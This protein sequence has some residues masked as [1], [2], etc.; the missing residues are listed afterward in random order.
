[1]ENAIPA[2]IPAS[3]PIIAPIDDVLPR[4]LWSVMIPTYNCTAFLKEALSS[5]LIQALGPE[6]MQIEVVDDASTD[7]DVAAVV[8]ALGGGRVQYFRQPVNVGS[9]RNFETCLNR[10][11][12]QLIHLLHGNDRV[13]TGFYERLT[14]L[15]QL[16]PTAGAASTHYAFIDEQGHRQC[17][18]APAPVAAEA[19]LLPN[20]L[21]RI[22]EYQRLQYV[23]VAVRRQ[24][25]EQ[26]GSFYGTSYGE[27]W[28]MWVRIAAHYPMAYDP[29]VLAEYRG[30][31]NSI[32][33]EKARS[34][35]I[36]PDLIQVI[37][38]IQQHLPVAD[39]SR[40]LSLSKRYYARMGIGT[41]YQALSEGQHW[42][43]ARFQIKQA[44][45]LSKHPSIY[46]H[47]LKFY[48]KRLLR[49]KVKS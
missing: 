37:A 4:P 32:S 9:I 21:L 47:V 12:G 16:Y 46:Y 10:A 44:L 2:R 7:E 38:F 29:T 25:Y 41:A 39:R 36:I 14:Q 24:V 13:T 23:S 3:P 11:R 48:L 45:A 43:L 49:Y 28:E 34:G 17:T 20:W 8:A 42:S 31:T 35:Q 26:L 1:M 6:I 33:A 30:H 19:G 22:A 15:F 27:D 5:V 40:I 18:P